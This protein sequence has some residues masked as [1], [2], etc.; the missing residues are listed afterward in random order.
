[1]KV[2][3]TGSSGLIG[4]EAVDFY[5]SMGCDVFGI[6]NN[7]REQFFGSFGSTLWNKERLIS[8][9]KNFTALDL[10]IRNET[11]IPKLFKNIKPDLIIHCAAQPSHDLAAKIPLLDF[12]VNANGT[13]NLL[14]AFRNNT[15]DS[16][17]I[18]LSTNK[19]YG[20]NPNFIPMKELDLRYDYDDDKFKNGIPETL[21]IDNCKHS[22]FGVSKAA[23][24]LLSQEYGKYFGLKIGIFRGGCLTGPSHSGVELHGFISYLIKSIV[25]KKSYTIYGY[26]GKQVRDQIHSKDVVLAFEEFRKNPKQGEVYN[27]GGGKNNSASIL[28]SIKMVCELTGL[29]GLNFK[30]AYIDAPR[31]G[32]HICY[33][34]DLG[35][36]KSHFPKWQITASLEDIVREIIDFESKSQERKKYA[37]YLQA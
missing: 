32:D 10:D 17:F 34:S 2:L 21:S 12:T 16:V 30:P 7:M 24:D 13:L 8:K 27:I 33:Y 11:E 9:F 18:F 28:E 1:M 36:I 29:A 15:S 3:I 26:K 5:C 31:S 22:L 14:E 6:D 4:S 35:K 23:G 19:V 25:N 37:K 20:D